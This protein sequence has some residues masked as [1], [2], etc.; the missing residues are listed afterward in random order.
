[1]TKIT[2]IKRVKFFLIKRL[3]SLVIQKAPLKQYYLEIGAHFLKKGCG[4]HV[5]Q[6]I[7]EKHLY[8]N[9]YR[10]KV[11]TSLLYNLKTNQITH[12]AENRIMKHEKS[13]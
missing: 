5:G 13:R 10:V 2:E 12:T 7:Q 11:I 4:Y 1:M 9:I 8:S 3:L 6:I